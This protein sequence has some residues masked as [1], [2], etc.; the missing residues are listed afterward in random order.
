MHAERMGPL[1]DCQICNDTMMAGGLLGPRVFPANWLLPG[2]YL[3]QD[4]SVAA[5][6]QCM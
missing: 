3:Q 5:L 6:N 1:E 4:Y 2:D